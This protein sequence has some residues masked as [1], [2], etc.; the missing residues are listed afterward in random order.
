[1][2]CTFKKEINAHRS[3][4]EAPLFCISLNSMEEASKGIADL[5]AIMTDAADVED[6]LIRFTRQ[7]EIDYA[8]THN[9][10]LFIFA[11]R[12]FF[13]WPMTKTLCGN[14]EAVTNIRN[15]WIH[16]NNRVYEEW[17]ISYTDESDEL[18][19]EKW[20]FQAKN[21]ILEEF[22]V[23]SVCGPPPVEYV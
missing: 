10:A 8:P 18:Q 1:M 4:T 23:S 19:W 21:S 9:I 12:S 15:T 13:C 6:I 7:L 20:T 11:L 5:F 17:L 2:G 22:L 3:K 16:Q 14:T